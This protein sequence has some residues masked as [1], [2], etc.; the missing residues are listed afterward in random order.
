[1]GKTAVFVL[2]TLHLVDP[3]SDNVQVLVLTHVRELAFQLCVEYQRFCKFMPG[4]KAM[5]VYGGV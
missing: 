2:T 5:V 1:M 3:E 4:V